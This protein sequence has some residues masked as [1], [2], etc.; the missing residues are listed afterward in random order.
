MLSARWL[1][2]AERDLKISIRKKSGAKRSEKWKCIIQKS[3]WIHFADCLAIVDKSSTS[4]AKYKCQA[5]SQIILEIVIKER[6]SLPSISAR[7]L[8]RLMGEP[9]KREG[10]LLV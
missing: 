5:K 6:Y 4:Y 9:M 8:L 2:V 3:H 7:K 10:Y 1:P